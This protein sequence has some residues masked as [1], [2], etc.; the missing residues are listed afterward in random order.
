M[1]VTRYRLPYRLVLAAAALA[2]LALTGCGDQFQF[3][4]VFGATDAGSPV[5]RVNYGWGGG[6]RG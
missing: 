2:L 6:G 1:S 4:P 3:R 5:S